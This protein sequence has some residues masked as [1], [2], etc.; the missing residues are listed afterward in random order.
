VARGA[1]RLT[2]LQEA[3][4]R[5]V[6]LQSNGYVVGFASFLVVAKFGEQFRTRCPVGLIFRKARI[7]RWLG[8]GVQRGFGPLQFCDCQS[9]IDG[10]HRRAGQAK[11]RS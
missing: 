11:S 10:N 8:H 3:S 5:W 4:Y 1:R 6:A 7:G 9:A 2:I